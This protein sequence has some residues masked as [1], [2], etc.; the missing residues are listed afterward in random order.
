MKKYFFS[1]FLFCFLFLLV[2]VVF[3]EQ[4][5][6]GNGTF[7][8]PEGFNRLHVKESEQQNG[9]VAGVGY[10]NGNGDLIMIFALNFG[11]DI[12]VNSQE[13]KQDITER[14][15]AT[16]IRTFAY[17]GRNILTATAKD[18]EGGVSYLSC[19]ARNGVIYF[20]NFSEKNTITGKK[21]ISPSGRNL[22]F[23]IVNSFQER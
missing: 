9:N 13:I 1:L 20:I 8:I 22:V 23:S 2:G 15:G 10:F 17:A 12:D 14:F 16:D 7:Y 19:F 5:Q 3:A 4:V 11:R 6:V 18:E 21:I